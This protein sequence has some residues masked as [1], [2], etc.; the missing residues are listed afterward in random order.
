M[1]DFY[2]FLMSSAL[3]AFTLF[4]LAPR[5]RWWRLAAVPIC[6]L[7]LGL[8]LRFC[9]RT[10]PGIYYPDSPFLN[11]LLNGNAL[12]NAGVVLTLALGVADAAFVFR[13]RFH[14]PATPS[15][16]TRVLVTLRAVLLLLIFAIIAYGFYYAVISYEHWSH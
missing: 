13:T 15:T 2:V 16:A 8:A 3:A 4:F 5:S 12:F 14:Q 1:S 11:S 6:V 10:Y 7:A 9:G